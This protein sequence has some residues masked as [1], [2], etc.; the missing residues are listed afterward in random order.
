MTE[1]EVKT[2][3]G[4]K[5]RKEISMTVEDI[6]VIIIEKLQQYKSIESADRRLLLCRDARSRCEAYRELLRI[7]EE[8]ALIND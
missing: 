3:T 5:K 7:I 8:R 6:R 4:G 2:E 1:I